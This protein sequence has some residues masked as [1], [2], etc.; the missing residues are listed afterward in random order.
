MQNRI[1]I[2]FVDDERNI[3]QGLRRMLR[4]MRDKWDLAFANG[5]NEAL[6]H[7]A[8]EPC[9]VIISDIRMPQMTG[10][11]LLENVR[12]RHPHM[13]RFVLSG[14]AARETIIDAVGPTHQYLAKPC[15]AETLKAAIGRLEM[16]RDLLPVEKLR[17]A[18]SALESLPSMPS[19]YDELTRQLRGPEVS[20]KSVCRIISA[21]IGMS[22][23]LLQL[24]GS[25]FFGPP[26][27]VSTPA[28]AAKVLGIDIIKSLALSLNVL[29]PFDPVKM[30]GFAM[31]TLWKHSTTVADHARKIAESQGAD[32]KTADAA[33]IAGMLHDVGKIVLAE[34]LAEDYRSA[35]ALARAEGVDSLEAERRIFGA[36]HAQVGAYLLGIWGLEDSTVEATAYHHC[37]SAASNF[38]DFTA[39]TAVHVAYCLDEGRAVDTEYLARLGLADSMT[40]WRDIRPKEIHKEPAN[41]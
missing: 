35:V 22:G 33:F 10:V 34:Q 27:H 3:L 9:D 2:I 37:P 19:L 28:E 17:E 21:D 11:E 12:R 31:G 14:Q 23:K 16:L 6:E 5:G 38:T 20:V 36:T 25:G 15:D 13:I 40:K 26:R 32:K 8:A 1:R 7:L 39:L 4:P 24:V 29:T 41:V 30:E 18:I